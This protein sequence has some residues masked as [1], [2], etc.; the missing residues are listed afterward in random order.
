MKFGKNRY[1]RL[2]EKISDHFHFQNILC[3]DHVQESDLRQP[4]KHLT[5]E[6]PNQTGDEI[7]NSTDM[8]SK[9]S[10]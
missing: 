3:D 7:N 2:R 9:C 8:I 6:V 1:P 5:D 10:A 4:A